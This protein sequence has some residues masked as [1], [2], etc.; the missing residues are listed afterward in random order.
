MKWVEQ[1]WSRYPLGGPTRNPSG[2]LSR[3]KGLAEFPDAV[4]SRGLKHINEL[5]K[6]NPYE[7]ELLRKRGDSYAALKKY[8]EALNDFNKA[9]EYEPDYARTAYESRSKIYKILGK[10]ELAA[11]DMQTAKRIKTTP[12]EKPIY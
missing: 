1:G 4:T 11:K 8:K 6:A 3:K 12:A 2:H 9:I 5:L 7:D 10:D